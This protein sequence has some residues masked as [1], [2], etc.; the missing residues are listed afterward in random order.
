MTD[1]TAI[2]KTLGY[3]FSDISHLKV[4]LTHKSAGKK[5]YEKLE[6]LG[7]SVLNF[8]ISHILFTTF[9]D[10]DEGTLSITRSKLVNKYILSHLG[11][12]LNVDKDIKTSPHQPISPSIRADVM[13]AIIGACFLDSDMIQTEHLIKRLFSSILKN[14][15]LTDVKDP[16]SLLQEYAHSK[17]LPAPKYCVVSISGHEHDRTYTV[18]CSIK[19]TTSTQSCKSKQRAEMLAAA[20]TLKQLKD[21]IHA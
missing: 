10:M 11:K 13:E 6:F 15:D 14:L 16:K 21:S 7:D 17:K 1:L 3:T 9:P 18:S 19:D 2:Q 12:S 5:H 20:A 8:A 4:A